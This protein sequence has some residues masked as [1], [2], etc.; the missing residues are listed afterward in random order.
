MGRKLKDGL[1]V[2]IRRL[3]KSNIN[4]KELLDKLVDTVVDAVYDDIL[5]DMLYDDRLVKMISEVSFDKNY[6]GNIVNKFIRSNNL[7]VVGVIH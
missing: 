5:T 3:V 4:D 2:K 7:I 1:D 6:V